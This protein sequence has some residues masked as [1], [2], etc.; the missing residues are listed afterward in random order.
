MMRIAGVS[1]LILLAASGAQAAELPLHGLI[2]VYDKERGALIDRCAEPGSDFCKKATEDEVIGCA[3]T[4]VRT[5]DAEDVTEVPK[6]DIAPL[7]AVATQQILV[8]LECPNGIGATYLLP[9]DTPE[10]G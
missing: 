2:V 3:I 1:A 6:G 4:H 10:D 9:P 5:L 7:K 8:G